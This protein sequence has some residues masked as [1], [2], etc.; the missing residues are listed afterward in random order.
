MFYTLSKVKKSTVAAATALSIMLA[1][2][3]GACSS[4]ATDALNSSTSNANKSNQNQVS[5][6]PAVP[7][8]APIDPAEA[9][10]G[11]QVEGMVTVSTGQLR[12]YRLYVPASLPKDT[13]VPLLIALHGGLGSGQQFEQQTGFD[14]L[15]ESNKFLVVY[16]N[17]SPS[18]KGSGSLVWN[19]GS[20][21]SIADQNAEN[22]ND[23]GFISAL[24]AQLEGQWDI[25][26]NSIFVT[27]HSNGA[28]LAERLACQLS[29]QIAA[30]AVQ[31]GTLGV[32]CASSQP[33]AVMEIHGTADQNIPINGGVGQ[34][35]LTQQNFLPPV[36]ALMTFAAQDGC[37]SAPALSTSQANH[38]V[39]Y[40]V[41]QPC[42]AGTVVEWVK[43]TGA[44]HAWMGHASTTASQRLVGQPYMGFDSSSAVWSFLAAHFRK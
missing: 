23:V 3:L 27:G 33:V 34:K 5:N 26:G 4:N 21:C 29:A 18:R 28:M 16:P 12:S 7:F 20:C 32:S 22:V 19:A 40:E 44:N 41:W 15:A 11:K 24:I 31:S 10:I 13:A 1:A 9:A 8:G 6:V 42:K 14:G 39:N 25:D 30:I 35:S 38:D 2:T 43:V 17:G 37:P 36:D